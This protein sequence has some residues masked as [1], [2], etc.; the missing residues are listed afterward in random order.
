M[1]IFAAVILTFVGAFT[2]TSSVLEAVARDIPA[3]RLLVF[4]LLGIL[5]IFNL[6]A[7]LFWLL[8]DLSGLRHRRIERHILLIIDIA[9][10]LLLSVSLVYL[11][12]NS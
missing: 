6:L 9:L 11:L 10:L 5:F 7:Y 4:S 3:P 1:S 8:R 12:K 2:A